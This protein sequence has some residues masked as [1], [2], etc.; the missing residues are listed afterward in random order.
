MRLIGIGTARGVETAVEVV[1]GSDQDLRPSGER[2][3]PR[4]AAGVAP[5]AGKGAQRDRGNHCQAGSGGNRGQVL[6]FDWIRPRPHR[7]D[8]IGPADLSSINPAC[9]ASSRVAPKSSKFQRA[10]KT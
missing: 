10:N 2:E 6:R 5:G 7:W 3:K 1:R 4:S 9:F 8:R